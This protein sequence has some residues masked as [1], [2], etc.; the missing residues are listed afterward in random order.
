MFLDHIASTW[1]IGFRSHYLRRRFRWAVTIDPTEKKNWWPNEHAPC[2][3]R[4]FPWVNWV[5]WTFF[6]NSIKPRKPSRRTNA[7]FPEVW[8][9]WIQ[10]AIKSQ[11]QHSSIYKNNLGNPQQ[12]RS[13]REKSQQKKKSVMT[14]SSCCGGALYLIAS[15]WIEDLLQSNCFE[16]LALE[17]PLHQIPCGR[18][19]KIDASK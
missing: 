18:T 13:E 19:H 2:Q 14:A 4:L 5:C 17:L 10:I 7:F 3:K 11:I 1:R 9:G 15:T 12:N 6:V 16:N 8:D